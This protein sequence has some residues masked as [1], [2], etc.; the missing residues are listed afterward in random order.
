[1]M[2]YTDFGFPRALASGVINSSAAAIP[3]IGIWHLTRRLTWPSRVSIPFYGLHACIGLV[4]AAVWMSSGGL[5]AVFHSELT[6]FEYFE[7]ARAVLWRIILGLFIYGC[8]TGVCYAV[9][10][11]NR[12]QEQTI[13]AHY[14]E[15]LAAQAELKSLRAR[16]SP[17]FIFNA[18]H[19]ISSLMLRDIE[20][21]EDAIERLG[22]LLRYVLEEKQEQL[23]SLSEELT[24]TRDYFELENMRLDN[25]VRLVLNVDDSALDFEIPPLLLQPLVENSMKHG[26]FSADQENFVKITALSRDDTLILEVEDNGVEASKPSRSQQSGSHY[27]IALL[28]ARLE[29]MYDGRAELKIEDRQQHGFY[30]KIVLPSVE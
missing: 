8:I 24:F 5:T 26:V 11:Q 4:F 21:A 7:N 19:S 1:M 16:L 10:N 23:I 30:V 28:S 6:F 27:G 13:R 2:T 12:L 18:L 20:K 22:H 17:H 29:K 15:G 14:A 9:R 25:S 3:G